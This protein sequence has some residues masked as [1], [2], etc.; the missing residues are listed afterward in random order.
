MLTSLQCCFRRLSYNLIILWQN[1]LHLFKATVSHPAC[2]F[3]VSGRAHR[4]SLVRSETEQGTHFTWSRSFRINFSLIVPILWLC[5]SWVRYIVL[6][7]SVYLDTY[8]HFVL[9]WENEIGTVVHFILYRGGAGRRRSVKGLRW[10]SNE[11][12]TTSHF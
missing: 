5:V 12:P 8:G 3:T 11:Q 1:N 4:L 2:T 6:N 7:L 10:N 9:R